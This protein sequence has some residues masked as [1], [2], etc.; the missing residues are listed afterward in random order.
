[1]LQAI[2]PKD[3][4]PLN[5]RDDTRQLIYVVIRFST[6]RREH[7]ALYH[8]LMLKLFRINVAFVVVRCFGIHN[9]MPKASLS[10][11]MYSL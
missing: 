4:C 10:C 2:V 9:N 5:R 6:L 7:T 8:D 3:S 1:M 11:L